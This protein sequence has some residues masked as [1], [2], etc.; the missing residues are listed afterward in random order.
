[1]KKLI[2]LYVGIL[3]VCLS[4]K[5]QN[6][7]KFGLQTGA[8]ASTFNT[9]ISISGNIGAALKLLMYWKKGKSGINIFI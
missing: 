3:C 6:D 7:L 5:A 1:M 8:A 2:L 9:A 4:L